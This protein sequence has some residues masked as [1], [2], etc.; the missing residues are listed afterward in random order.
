MQNSLKL[1]ASLVAVAALAACTGVPSTTNPGD[2][3]EPGIQVSVFKNNQPQAN[4]TVFLK[5]F[6]GVAEG[7]YSNGTAEGTTA[8]TDSNGIAFLPV[9]AAA[10]DSGLFGAAYDISKEDA[11][12]VDAAKNPDQIQWFTTPAISLANK[13]GKRASV[14]IDIGWDTAAFSPKY[15]DSVN[16][17]NVEFSLPTKSGA[18]EYEVLV[19][20]GNVAG[21]GSKAYDEKNA[22]GKFTWTGASAGTYNYVGK[23]FTSA[24]MGQAST[25]ALVFTVK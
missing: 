18:T 12:K 2:M 4:V 22:T 14:S 11:T 23:F 17:G 20:Q 7:S 25:S 13:T 8:K 6:N 10:A 19:N 1:G 9:P 15:G 21:S 24:G 3:S 16:A 5:K